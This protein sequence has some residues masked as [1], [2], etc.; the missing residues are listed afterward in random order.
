MARVPTKIV[1]EK[2]AEFMKANPGAKSLAEICTGVESVGV[3]QAKVY[4][5]AKDLVAQKILSYEQKRG[6]IKLFELIGDIASATF[7]EKAEKPVL[8]VPDAESKAE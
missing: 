2:I 5:L 4:Y 3:K 1:A 7:K 6:K 8:E